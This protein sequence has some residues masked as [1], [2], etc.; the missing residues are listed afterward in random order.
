MFLETEKFNHSWNLNI[1]I[2]LICNSDTLRFAG[3][4]LKVLVGNDLKYSEKVV[5]WENQRTLFC[6]NLLI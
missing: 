2:W 3:N 6:V 1:S 5:Y 4:I